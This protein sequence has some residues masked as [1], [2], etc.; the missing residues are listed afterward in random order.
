MIYT[1][2]ALKDF[3]ERTDGTYT[4]RKIGDGSILKFPTAT[5]FPSILTNI[6][7]RIEEHSEYSKADIYFKD[8]KSLYNLIIDGVNQKVVLPDIGTINLTD[9]YISIERNDG[10]FYYDKIDCR[11]R[12][13]YKKF[14]TF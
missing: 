11:K 8:K 6:D 7:N 3:F 2:N 10:T 4:Y 14:S 12:I 13:V 1:L 9:L 5:I